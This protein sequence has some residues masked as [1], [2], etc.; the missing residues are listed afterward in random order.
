MYKSEISLRYVSDINICLNYISDVLCNRDPAINLKSKADA[1]IDEI[2]KNPYIYTSYISKIKLKNEHKKAKVNNYY[3][4]F[5][6]DEARKVVQIARLIFSKMDFSS[7]N[8][9]L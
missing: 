8:E 1:T 6:I 7:I 4:F 5:R 2:A 3:M 9:I